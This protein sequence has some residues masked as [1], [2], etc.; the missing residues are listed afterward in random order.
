VVVDSDEALLLA[1]RAGDRRA[2]NQLFQ[3][4]YETVRRFF[5]N[6][7]DRDLEDL[8]QRT[9]EGCMKGQER[10]EGRSSF[11]AY[12]RGIA[13]HLLLQHWESRRARDR[14]VDIDELSLAELGAGPSSVLAKSQA[15]KRLL[16]A[17]RQ[18]PLK[19]QE[20]LELFYWENLSGPALA[21]VL[22]M[23]ENT[24]RSRLRRAKL[25]LKKAYLRLERFAGVPES[26]NHDLE[27][28]ARGL[29]GQLKLTGSQ[30]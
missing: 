29:R 11:L 17:L 19:D 4:H 21:E 9:F 7:V 13:R 10:F 5:I 24:V 1:W 20:L 12:L 6:K 18:L 16:D 14:D 8:I 22:G 28:W 23:P 2:G 3:R 30:S 26:S 27:D 25:A 15:D